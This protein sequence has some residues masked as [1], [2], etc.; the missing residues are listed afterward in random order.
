VYLLDEVLINR[1][2]LFL[3]NIRQPPLKRRHSSYHILDLPCGLVILLHDFSCYKPCL[4]T[5]SAK[6]G[7]IIMLKLVQAVILN[8]WSSAME[9]DNYYKSLL[10]CFMS[11]GFPGSW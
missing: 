2:L 10:S 3:W 1:G 7:T 8:V 9:F 6:F 5:D 11:S 4:D